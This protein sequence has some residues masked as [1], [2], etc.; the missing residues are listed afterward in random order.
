MSGTTS[1]CFRA[2]QRKLDEH[3]L[4][5]P[6]TVRCSGQRVVEIDRRRCGVALQRRGD[7]GRPNRGFRRSEPPHHRRLC[8][9]DSRRHRRR[10]R[11]PAPRACRPARARAEAADAATVWPGTADTR[12]TI[13]SNGAETMSSPCAP[14]GFVDAPCEA[15]A[16]GRERRHADLMLRARLFDAAGT[17][18]AVLQQLFESLQAL[19]GRQFPRLRRP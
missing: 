14:T 7:A 18:G 3:A 6:E 11:R 13:P 9:V 15:L 12:C 1:P 5:R 16:G 2:P 17:R 8:F 10:R 19:A 4:A